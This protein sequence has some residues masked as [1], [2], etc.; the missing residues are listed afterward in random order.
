MRSKFTPSSAKKTLPWLW[1]R[2][3]NRF[4]SEAWAVVEVSPHAKKIAWKG[5][6]TSST[7]VAGLC[8]RG[9]PGL[10]CPV[11][12]CLR[13]PPEHR[14]RP[15]RGKNEASSFFP[16]FFLVFASFF[17]RFFL[18]R[19]PWNFGGL[20]FSSF[21]PQTVPVEF[22]G[23]RFFLKHHPPSF[24]SLPHSHNDVAICT[25]HSSLV[26]VGAV[27]AVFLGGVS[28]ETDFGLPWKMHTQLP[29]LRP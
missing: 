15:E 10:R 4:D 14:T 13:I 1:N 12:N 25:N 26:T 28:T 2:L 3:L 7:S 21:F 18:K 22:L 17:P 24:S 27:A 19:S 6:N 20:V 11:E 9:L 16:R 23:P 29:S 8:E 5:R